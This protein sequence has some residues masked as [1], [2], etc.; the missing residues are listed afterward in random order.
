MLSMSASAPVVYLY[1][2]PKTEVHDYVATHMPAHYTGT[3]R[4]ES[5]MGYTILA[6]ILKTKFE[7][8]YQAKNILTK[9]DGKPYIKDSSI[10]FN[11][12]Y[13]QDY[14]ACAVGLQEIGID[15]EQPRRLLPKLLPKILTREEINDSVDPLQ[16]WVIKEAY[17]K[18][19]GAG[20]ALGFTSI[21]VETILGKQPHFIVSNE[22][23]TCAV[24]YEN[25]N[26]TLET[27]YILEGTS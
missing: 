22:P 18:L 25:P 17:G 10:C 9:P 2:I 15:I 16:A 12:S 11:I 21:S 19:L 6:D 4:D 27:Q 1:V 23:Y 14:V 20:L 24:F 13:S 8:I 3:I 5:K 7:I 26:T